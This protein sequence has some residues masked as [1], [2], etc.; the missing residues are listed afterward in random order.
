MESGSH[1]G[2]HPRRAGQSSHHRYENDVKQ[3]YN[4]CFASLSQFANFVRVNIFQ[5]IR[6]IEI[7][8]LWKETGNK[9]LRQFSSKSSSFCRPFCAQL[10]LMFTKSDAQKYK[11]RWKSCNCKKVHKKKLKAETF[12]FRNKIFE[13]CV[14]IFSWHLILPIIS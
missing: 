7:L 11:N 3:S 9:I 6:V 8:R 2:C 5:I 14:C 4:V 13:N 10:P 1:S 12:P